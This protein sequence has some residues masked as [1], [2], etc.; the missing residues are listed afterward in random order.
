MVCCT[1]ADETPPDYVPGGVLAAS[2]P[3]RVTF[4]AYRATNEES[5]RLEN[6][7]MASIEGVLAYLSQE[8]V[9]MNGN[10][11]DR[12]FGID[13][14]R[15]YRITM[16]STTE[17]FDTTDA[18]W[19][20]TLPADVRPQFMR[21]VAFDFGQIAW[22]PPG[23]P[24]VG[25][26]VNEVYKNF[27]QHAYGENATYFSL[28]GRC[29]HRKFLTNNTWTPSYGDYEGVKTACVDTIEDPFDRGN[30]SA[31]VSRF[32]AGDAI[33]EECLRWQPDPIHSGDNVPRYVLCKDED[34]L[35]R[36]KGGECMAPDGDLDDSD[37]DLG[38]HPKEEIS[39]CTWN[40]VPI[41]EVT[42][43]ELEGM[44]EARSQPGGQCF[45]K[46]HKDPL[47]CH[48]RVQRL[49]ALFRN[50]YPDIPDDM[51]SPKCPY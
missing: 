12:K 37:D 13:R 10:W 35:A 31:C 19:P 15:R 5:Y 43:D 23:L 38:G 40:A 24:S 20:S 8:V 11:A 50:K 17:A 16:K 25:C 26:A 2:A 46:N 6:V 18:G 30:A 22:E 32:D 39:G 34:C 48:E 1:P 36:E 42:L 47:R 14:I 51:P 9:G 44:P 28:P 27:Y 4:Y 7:N 3:K 49:A 41:G 21:Y 29:Y 33:P 45:W